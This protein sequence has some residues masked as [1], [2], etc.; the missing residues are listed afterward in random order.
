MFILEQHVIP[1]KQLAQNSF[2]KKDIKNQYL[3]LSDDLG[4]WMD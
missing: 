2:I 4:I 3:K 1:I